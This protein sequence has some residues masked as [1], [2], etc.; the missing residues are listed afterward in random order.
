M[1]NSQSDEELLDAFVKSHDEPAFRCLAERYSGLIFH[2]ALRTLNDRT[3]AEDVSQRVLGVLARKASQVSR[4]NAPLPS[5]LHRT[6]ILE[7]KS[8]RRIESRH[9]RKKDALMRAPNESPAS[10]DSA[11]KDA[12]PHLDAAIDTLPESDRHVLLL[13]FVNELTF[14]EIATRLGK[15]A[16]AVQKQS[17]RA[18]EKLQGILGRRGVALSIGI[19]TAGLTTEMAKAGPTLLIPALSSL[20]KT[21]TSILVVK[22]TTVAALGTTLLLCGIPLARQQATLIQ[23]ESKLSS[24]ASVSTDPRISS[25]NGAT[26]SPSMIERLARDL[27]AKDHDMLRYLAAVDHI[28]SLPDEELI[29][30]IREIV[31][32]SLPFRSQEI[33]FGKIFDT[34]G[35]RDIEFALNTLM[36]VVPRDYAGKSV[37]A[38]GLLVNGLRKFSEQD[39]KRALAWF[40]DHLAR[41]RTIPKRR[42]APEDYEVRMGLAY[43]LVFSEPQAAVEVLSPLPAHMLK[44]ELSQLVRSCDPSLRKDA[45]GFIQVARS[46]FP[47]N[48]A[49]DVV[50]DLIDVNFAGTRFASVDALLENYEFTAGEV[51]AILEKAGAGDFERASRTPGGMEKAIF[52]YKSWLENRNADDIDQR[53]GGSLG[54][55]VKWWSRT[56]EPIYEAMLRSGE[57][58]LGDA[59]IVGLLETAGFALG[60]EKSG[61]LAAMLSD[62]ETARDLLLKIRTDTSR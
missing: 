11:W 52:G 32:S 16:A 54:K 37:T 13:H 22:K 40:H 19:L 38:R 9:H 14:P 15:S 42:G 58:G 2:T 41:I 49:N 44:S 61:Q 21:T 31:G 35:T 51:N 5:W 50:A 25:R 27:K 62:P 26:K 59:A 8:A 18:L 36:D 3:L 53:V 33:V 4:G 57:M 10:D 47:E 30:L 24:S 7:A 34:L 46:L 55:A 29:A 43:G 1:P 45:T 48:E 60:M 12:L 17:R 28:E 56:S 39:G 20:G 23:L 6:T